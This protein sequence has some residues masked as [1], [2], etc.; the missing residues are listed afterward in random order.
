MARIDEPLGFITASVDKHVKVWSYKGEDWGDILIVGENPVRKWSFPYDWKKVREKDKTE[1][2]DV[3]KQIEP[4]VNPESEGIQFEEIL[5]DQVKV[6]K[7]RDHDLDIAPK[8]CTISPEVI[9]KQRRQTN[10][11]YKEEKAKVEDDDKI[12]VSL[13]Q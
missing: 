2:I 10:K 5:D 6:M 4:A 3:M 13:Y 11:V 12:I 7:R 8:R 1:V 9:E